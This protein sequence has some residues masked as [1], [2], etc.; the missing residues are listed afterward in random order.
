MDPAGS[1]DLCLNGGKWQEKS[2]PCGF[3]QKQ[4]HAGSFG[5]SLQILCQRGADLLQVAATQALTTFRSSARD[6]PGG[7]SAISRGWREERAAPPDR[8]SAK[9]PIPEGS[10]ARPDRAP[11]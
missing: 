6:H 8:T 5:C 4:N 10:P 11:T 3:E 9:K 1:R 2:L 7:M